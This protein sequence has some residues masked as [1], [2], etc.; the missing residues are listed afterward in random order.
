MV[1]FGMNLPIITPREKAQ[2]TQLTGQ[3][4]TDKNIRAM[5]KKAIEYSLTA[6]R[7]DFDT[8]K[9]TSSKDSYEFARKFYHED[10]F[11]YESLFIILL[12]KSNNATG[13]AKISQ[14]GICGTVVDSIIISKYAIDTLSSG[15]ILVHNHPSGN[16]SPS[17]NDLNMTTKVKNALKLFDIN[18]IDSL[19]ISNDGYMSFC[20]EG[21]I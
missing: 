13:Y 5:E 19:I 9:I 4:V 21:I 1:S 20:D 16:L 18:L 12:N 14:G 17:S 7:Q 3:C 2:S 10:I 8:T 11:I 15:V 6:K